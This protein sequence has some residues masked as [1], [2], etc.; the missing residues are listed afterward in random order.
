MKSTK[1]AE[2]ELRAG[3]VRDYDDFIE[4]LRSSGEI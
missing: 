4:E 3:R 1:E 2:E